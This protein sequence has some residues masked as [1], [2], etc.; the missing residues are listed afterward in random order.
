MSTIIETKFNEFIAKNAM[1]TSVDVANSIKQHGSWIRNSEVASWLRSNALSNA[2]SYT[3]TQIQVANG[4]HRATLYY[5][6]TEN[7]DNY[8]DRDQIALPPTQSIAVV[9]QVSQQPIPIANQSSSVSKFKIRS[10]GHARLRIPAH[11][12]VQLGLL[13]GDKV[14]KSKILV[15]NQDIAD[16]LTVHKDGRI[17][18]LRKCVAWGDGPVLVF[19]NNN[20]LCFEKP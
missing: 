18:I 16:D 7:P 19:I 8:L 4:Q 9:N 5:P 11:L 13:P 10:D 2:P 3:S 12:V 17:A 6:S 15:N 1:F 20:N 14:D